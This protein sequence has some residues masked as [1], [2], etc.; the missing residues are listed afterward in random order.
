MNRYDEFV[1][2]YQWVIVM[3]WITR[4]SKLLQRTFGKPVSDSPMNVKQF[5]SE[6]NASE[7]LLLW[8]TNITEIKTSNT[9]STQDAEWKFFLDELIATDREK[10]LGFIFEED[11]RRSFASI[12]IQ[13][14][15]IRKRLSVF[16][17]DNYNIDRTAEVRNIELCINRSHSESE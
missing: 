17:D 14:A 13:R 16:D 9:T 5:A 11:Q 10:V 15:M 2:L 1:L 6:E 8:C 12:M 7:E 4:S 3:D